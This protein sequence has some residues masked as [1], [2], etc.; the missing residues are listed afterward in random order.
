MTQLSL[1]YIILY[2]IILRVITI[3]IHITISYIFHY[4]NIRRLNSLSPTRSPSKTN[5]PRH[6][7]IPP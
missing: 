7:A 5:L 2:R 4:L 6:T 3:I 1:Q